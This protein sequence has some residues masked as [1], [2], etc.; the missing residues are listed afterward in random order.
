MTNDRETRAM[1]R[2]LTRGGKMLQEAC[3]DCG[4]PLFKYDGEVVCAVCN[5]R[6]SDSSSE[7]ETDA[8]EEG[9]RREKRGVTGYERV[10]GDEATHA[11]DWRDAT[12]QHLQELAG[13]LA[14]E[15]RDE[16]DLSRLKDRL[17]ALERTTELIEKMEGLGD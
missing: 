10:S 16:E 12:M 6:S 9:Q 4:S 17:D 11:E 8:E 15:A 13:R 3:D 5:E 14:S 2:L 7:S 1:S